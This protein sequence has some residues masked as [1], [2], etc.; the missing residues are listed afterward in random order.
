MKDTI[1]VGPIHL[2]IQNCSVK[3]KG[4]TVRLTPVESSILRFLM[5]HTNT[6]CTHHQISLH[7]WERGDDVTRFMLKAH[8]RQLRQKVEP[9]PMHPAYILTV[10]GEGYTLQEPITQ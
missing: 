1:T 10:P 9:D 4:K 6:V 8:I 5:E 2:D 3:T 7:T